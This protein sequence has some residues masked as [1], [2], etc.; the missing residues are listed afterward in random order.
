MSATSDVSNDWIVV[1]S[2]L[3]FVPLRTRFPRPLH[4]GLYLLEG[5]RAPTPQICSLVL[6]SV[7]NF[8][9]ITGLYGFHGRNHGP[10]NA[11]Q[12]KPTEFR[13]AAQQYSSV[14]AVG[15]EPTTSPV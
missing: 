12:S 3:V 9:Q 1:V 7:A 11:A 5:K 14:G 8:V 13:K 6:P 2:L 15:I 10:S 4:E